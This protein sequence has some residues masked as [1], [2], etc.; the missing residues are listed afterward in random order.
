MS[1]R[2]RNAVVEG[3]A[4]SVFRRQAPVFLLSFIAL[5]SGAAAQVTGQRTLPTSCQPGV[6]LDVT[7]DLDVEESQKPNG[8]IVVETLPVGWSL[9]AATPA[10]ASFNPATGEA[11]W[12]FFGAGVSDTGLDISYTVVPLQGANGQQ[13]FA[14]N[15]LFNDRDG[16]PQTVAI[17]GDAVISCSVQPACVGDCDGSTQ[18]TVNEVITMVNIA[19]GNADVAACVAGDQDGSREITIDEIIA[20]VNN[21]LN[22]CPS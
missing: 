12:V 19:L 4:N 6:G 3:R 16:N 2:V 13:T 14:G 9:L 18:V 11:R 7:L 1:L 10:Q 5:S 20:A 17:G 8:V 22:G 21:A 15:I